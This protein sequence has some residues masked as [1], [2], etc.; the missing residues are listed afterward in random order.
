MSE[1]SKRLRN[2]IEESGFSYKELEEMTGIPHASIQRYAS[3]NT[4][5]IPI[6]RLE[7]LAIAVGTTAKHLLGWDAGSIQ[8][9]GA[10]TS[11]ELVAL[12]DSLPAEKQKQ[13]LD[14]AKYLVETQ[15]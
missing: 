10:K 4:D 2:A 5:H 13:L 15:I 3:R 1:V 7:K 14:F 9:E 11:D 12:F 6:S 8:E